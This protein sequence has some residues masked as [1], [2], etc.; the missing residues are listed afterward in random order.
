M[1]KSLLKIVAF[2]GA[3]GG[4]ATLKRGCWLSA[5]FWPSLSSCSVCLENRLRSELLPCE[6]FVQRQAVG[7]FVTGADANCGLP[8]NDMLCSSM[9]QAVT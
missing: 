1:A 7:D 3:K 6:I 2:S 8:F 5:S 9:L 4:A